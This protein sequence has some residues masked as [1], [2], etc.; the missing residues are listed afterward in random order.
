MDPEKLNARRKR[1][2]IDL[3]LLTRWI[4]KGAVG[5]SSGSGDG[6]EGTTLISGAVVSSSVTFPRGEGTRGECCCSDD[7]TEE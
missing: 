7:G 3:R 6:E 4:T 2:E 5:G 1:E